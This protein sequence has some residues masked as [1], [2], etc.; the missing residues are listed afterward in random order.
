MTTRRGKTLI[1]MVVI[2]S[3]LSMLLPLIAT[4]LVLVMKVERQV[5]A[6]LAQQTI[7]AR[8]G[9]RFRTDAHTAASARLA[10]SAIELSLPE[11][12][13]IRYAAGDAGITREVLRGGNVEHRDAFRLP[14][15]ARAELLLSDSGSGQLARIAI[16]SK[17]LAPK[18]FEPAI[19]PATIEAAVNL[20]SASSEEAP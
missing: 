6:D 19:R 18:R 9:S 17:P 10:D 14:S 2:V 4:T 5:R 8:L 15:H 7:L 13:T 11:E 20:H 1:E 12:R 16:A 3:C